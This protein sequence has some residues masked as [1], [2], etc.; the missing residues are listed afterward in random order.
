M[1]GKDG[2][3]RTK[4]EEINLLLLD[5]FTLFC[6]FIFLCLLFFFFY[7]I[8]FVVFYAVICVLNSSKALCSN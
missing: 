2:T 7:A 8:F 5:A 6:F 1:R 3:W 4:K